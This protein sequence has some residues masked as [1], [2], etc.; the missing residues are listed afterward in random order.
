MEYYFSLT[1]NQPYKSAV[2]IISPAEQSQMVSDDVVNAMLQQ[3]FV[4]V[5]D[6]VIYDVANNAT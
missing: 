5:A 1:T 4:D 6:I 3:L 2:A